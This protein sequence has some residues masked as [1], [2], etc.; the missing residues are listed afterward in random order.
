M[1]RKMLGSVASSHRTPPTET[2]LQYRFAA[3]LSQYL[4]QKT[5]YHRAA[6]QANIIPHFRVSHVVGG[7]FSKR[8]TACHAMFAGFSKFWRVGPHAFQNSFRCLEVSSGAFRCL[9]VSS[10]V[11]Q[12]PSGAAY[13]WRSGISG[14]R[15]PFRLLYY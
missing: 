2:V 10:G 9:Q 12:V 6:F 5:H 15:A 3:L 8:R 7:S 4:L 14:V 11:L 1:N 13:L